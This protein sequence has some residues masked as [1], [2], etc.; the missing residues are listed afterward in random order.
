MFSAKINRLRAGSSVRTVHRLRTGLRRTFYTLDLLLERRRWLYLCGYFF[1][2]FLGMLEAISEMSGSDW[3]GK[4][5]PRLVV[6]PNVLLG[7]PALARVVALER[8]SGSL[9]LALAVP[10]TERYF[11]RRIAPVCSLMLLQSWIVLAF[12]SEGWE[13]VRAVLQASVLAFFLS[14]LALFWASRLTTSGAVLVASLVS[15]ALM[16]PWIFVDPDTVP[17]I[18]GTDSLFGISLPN[19]A[20]GWRAFVLA[21][22]TAILYLYARQRLRRPEAMLA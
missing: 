20:W 19:L 21:L 5:Y 1:L 11:I 22:A 17:P 16:S 2:L 9:D 8:Q 6:A 15:V 13:L 12:L 18:G 10:S 3:L 14:A 7:L 4:L